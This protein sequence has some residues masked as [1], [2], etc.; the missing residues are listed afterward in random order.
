MIYISTGLFENK[1]SLTAKKFIKKE[2]YNIELSAGKYDKNYLDSLKLLK[3]NNKVSLAVHNYF[4]TPRKRFVFNLASLNDKIF[5]LS[6]EHAKKAIRLAKKLGGKYYSFHAGFLI[7]PKINTLGKKLYSS[8]VYPRKLCIK[9]FI[10]R[11]NLLSNYAAKQNIEILIENNVINKRN[12]KNFNLNPLLMTNASE[13]IHFMKKTKKN[14]NLLIDVGHLKVSSRTEKFD[15]IGY[16]KKVNKWI[17]GYHLSDNNGLEDQNNKIKINSWFWKYLNKN[18]DYISLEIK[19]KNLS[20]LKGQLTLT[21]K[22]LN[23]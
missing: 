19:N 12:I 5:K 15:K 1:A 2:I 21:K 23:D 14:V 18:V 16:L 3:R 22:I 20:L 13:A 17:K 9:K 10:Q 6:F 11:V 8:K 7:D 4:P